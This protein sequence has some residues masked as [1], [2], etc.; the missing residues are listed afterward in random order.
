MALFASLGAGGEKHTVILPQC[1]DHVLGYLWDVN[2][3]CASQSAPQ[4]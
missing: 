4:F 2:I 1:G 3:L